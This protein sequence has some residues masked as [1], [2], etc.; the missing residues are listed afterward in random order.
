M[1]E[2]VHFVLVRVGARECVCVRLVWSTEAIGAT[3]ILVTWV[4]FFFSGYSRISGFGFLSK[5]KNGVD[6]CFECD[7]SLFRIQTLTQPHPC[8]TIVVIK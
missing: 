7:F 1:L 2:I 4:G 5:N 6:M 3:Q 8:F